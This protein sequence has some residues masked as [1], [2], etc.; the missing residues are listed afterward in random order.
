MKKHKGKRKGIKTAALLLLA[1]VLLQSAALA[2]FADVPD[3]VWYAEYVTPLNQLGIING[4]D[5]GLFH[6]E[7]TL[8]RGEFIKL[9]YESSSLALVDE[10]VTVHWAEPYWKAAQAAGVLNGVE[11]PCT[12]QALNAGISRYEMAQLVTNVLTYQFREERSA[13]TGA[14]SVISDHSAIPAQYLNA[15]EQVYAKGIITGYDDG[16][17]SGGDTL[18]RGMA[19][20]VIY[21]MLYPASRRPAD[22]GRQEEEDFQSFAWYIRENNLVD[23]Y[24]RPGPELC[25]MLFGDPEKTYFANSQEAE[26]FM[27]QVTVDVWRINSAGAKY[28]AKATITVHKLLAEDVKHIFAD[29]LASPE[30]FPIKN[31]GGARFTDTMRHA[32]GCAIDINYNENGY[33][34]Y[35][36]DG[37]FVCASGSGWWPGENAYSI[38][39]DGSVVAAFAKYGWGWGGQGYSSGKYDYMHFSIMK[40]GG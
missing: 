5:D 40:S 24:G 18:T 14:D 29:I 33:G 23:A 16:S 9:I 3:G 19:A 21:R 26:P 8:R 10:V 7:N 32:W 30:Q 12:A 39:P 27:E 17:F 13:V 1:A 6:A 4:C 25:E 15:V 37:N 11:I 31:V 20:A 35:D 2:A 28:A 36:D 22:F 34:Y 38:T